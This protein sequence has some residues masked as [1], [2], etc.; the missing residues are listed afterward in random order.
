[1]GSSGS[2]HVAHNRELQLFYKE[3]LPRSAL[4]TVKA[5][6]KGSR[7]T[8]ARKH[9][10]ALRFAGFNAPQSLVWGKLTRGRE[11][12]FSGAVAGTGVDIWLRETLS[13]QLTHNLL[14]R[15]SFLR[16]L[17]VFVGRLH[18]TGFI[19]GDLRSSNVLAHRGSHR[20]E[21]SLID[22]ER[23]AQYR[24]PPG[25]LLLKNLMQLNMHL[26]GELSRCDRLRFFRAW[27]SQMRDL[28]PLEAKLIASASYQWAIKRLRA[29]GKL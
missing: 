13:N 19:H 17:G 28:S 20:F 8:R 15:R 18:A 26:P 10:E 2:A 6:L 4:E 22:N 1:M 24:P 7:A 27:H 12:L 3:F 11:Y 25:K 9:S 29:K 21:F 14:E 5:L 16:Q 23:N